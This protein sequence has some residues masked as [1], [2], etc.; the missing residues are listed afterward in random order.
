MGTEAVRDPFQPPGAATG[1]K[2]HRTAVI[3]ACAVALV[4]LIALFAV[5][6]TGVVRVGRP[7]ASS[8]ATARSINASRRPVEKV[9]RFASSDSRIYCTAR[10]RAFEDT[11]VEA[12]W[13]LGR[14]LVKSFARPFSALT[15]VS[16]GR[17][18][19]TA[20]DVA[21]YIE[22]PP[23]GWGAGNYTV[24]VRLDGKA[25]GSAAFSVS[26]GESAEQVPGVST[27]TDSGGAFS[28]SYPAGWIEADPDSLGDA[29]AGF[30]SPVKG[31]Y[32]AR[33][34][35]LLTDYASAEPDY[36][37]GLL[38]KEAQPQ[39]ETFTAYSLGETRGARRT[40]GWAMESG[41]STLQLKSIQVVMPG[42]EGVYA[43]N[44]HSLASEFD[45]NLAAF[46]AIIN[47]FRVQ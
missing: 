10:V 21:F 46:N 18:F 35:V 9:T 29:L 15:G 39:Q 44:C 17:L 13:R 43:L 11:V 20:A 42:V 5:S 22:T 25:S 4:A 28:V 14:R 41:D 26:G 47:S 6:L 45:E 16:A 23:G 3:T 37:N 34:A 12:R 19:T 40:Y 2:G 32:P 1:L 36:L 7:A 38:A 31:E 24:E 8:V 27:Y 33:F 30:V